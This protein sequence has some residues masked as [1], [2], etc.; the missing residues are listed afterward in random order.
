MLAEEEMSA[1]KERF[2]AAIKNASQAAALG[3][4]KKGG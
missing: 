3:R 4:R 2:D 1:M